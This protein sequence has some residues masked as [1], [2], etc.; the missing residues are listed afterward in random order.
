MKGMDAKS[1]IHYFLLELGFVAEYV[2]SKKRKFRADW[3]HIEKRIL[4]EYEG[5]Y[6]DKSRHTTVSGYVNDTTK[7]NLAT[8]E[9]WRVLRYTAKN[10]TEMYNDIKELMK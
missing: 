1:N 5:I 8:V 2:F 3:A 6:S 4:V 7:Y 9:G 10:Y